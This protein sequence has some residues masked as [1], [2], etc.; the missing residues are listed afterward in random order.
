[1]EEDQVDLDLC[2][3]DKSM[4]QHLHSLKIEV[5]KMMKMGMFHC[6]VSF[7]HL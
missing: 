3:P 5:W 6:H 1:M 7:G 4:E 2:L